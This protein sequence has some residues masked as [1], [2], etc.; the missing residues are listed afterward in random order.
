MLLKEEAFQAPGFPLSYSGIRWVQSIVMF[1]YWM[2]RGKGV[3]LVKGE[4]VVC[5][6]EESLGRNMVKN[7]EAYH[8]NKLTEE[9]FNLK[10]MQGYHLF[11]LLDAR[12]QKEKGK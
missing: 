3:K 4:I 1:S 8:V 12:I 6:L 5:E 10:E 7:L 11:D 2:R 9:E